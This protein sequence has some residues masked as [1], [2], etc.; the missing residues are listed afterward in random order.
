MVVLDGITDTELCTV[1]MVPAARGV[2]EIE[3]LPEGVEVSGI[4]GLLIAEG[5]LDICWTFEGAGDPVS[6]AVIVTVAE[7]DELSFG[8]TTTPAFS[9]FVG[10]GVAEVPVNGREVV[11]VEEAETEGVSVEALTTL[12]ETV[13]ES[14]GVPGSELVTTLPLV[15]IVA[16]T[17]I[18]DEVDSN[19]EGIVLLLAEGDSVS[20][21]LR[22]EVGDLDKD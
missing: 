11:K 1:L 22:L 19:L 20:L 18:E 7:T 13:E 6:T 16:E 2:G 3:T 8:D 12:S 14:E 21:L 15:E 17:L 5:F 10:M 9:L 4:L